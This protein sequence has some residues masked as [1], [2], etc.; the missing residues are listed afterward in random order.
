MSTVQ[1]IASTAPIAAFAEPRVAQTAPVQSPAPAQTRAESQGRSTVAD[2]VQINALEARDAARERAKETKAAAEQPAKYAS[3]VGLVD[4]TLDAFVDIVDARFQR[5]I[6]RIF[7]PSEAP[8]PA[9]DV[10]PAAVS[11]AYEHAAETASGNLR[12]SA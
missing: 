4:G 3:K 9:A 12:Q 7:G 8:A 10:P 11:K 6:A 5:K 2:Q 1:S